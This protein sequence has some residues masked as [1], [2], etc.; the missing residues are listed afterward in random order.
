MV[1]VIRNCRRNSFAW[2]HE[3]RHQFQEKRWGLLSKYLVADELLKLL[4]VL[5]VLVQDWFFTAL[6]V[7]SLFFISTALEFDAD[8]YALKETG[9]W[10]AW[11]RLKGVD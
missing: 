9:D 11:M 10:R 1:V 7:F 6:F 4:A 2:F 8:L 5:A 3:K